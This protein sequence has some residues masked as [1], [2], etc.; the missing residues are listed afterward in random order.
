[1]TKREC[2]IVQAYTGIC[3]LAGDDLGY[4]YEYVQE[5]M[6][7]PLWTHE[8]ADKHVVGTI[9]ERARADFIELCRTAVDVN[10]E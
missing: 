2:A 3:M 7:G 5:L 8:L 9:K 6:G 4:F 10:D 1:M